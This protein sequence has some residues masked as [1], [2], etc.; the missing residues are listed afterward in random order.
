MEYAS[1]RDN[2]KSG[3]LICLSHKGWGSIKDIESQI[4]RIVTESEFSHVCVV[5]EFLGR[6]FV[7][8]AVV[9]LVRI[10][11]LSTMLEEDK[12]V[13][14][15]PLS[16]PMTE[17]ETEFAMGEV[18][19]G[20][21]SKWQAIEGELGTLDIGADRKWQCSELTIAMRKL[22]GVDLGD[23]ATPA[24]VVRKALQIGSVVNYITKDSNV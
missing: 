16:T 1:V 12:E 10:T 22:S 15:L 21:Y 5:W 18:G 6:L 11:P 19:V 24:A 9:P 4:V 8:E 13:Y 20:A 23:K 14:W 17:A 2:I 7:I 3:D